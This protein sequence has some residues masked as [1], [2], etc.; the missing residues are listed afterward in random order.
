MKNLC[1]AGGS[2]QSCAAGIGKQIQHPNRSACGGHFIPDKIPVGCLLRK[3][4][5]MLKIHGLDIKSQIILISDLP[6]L[7]QMVVGPV[8]AAGRG[9]HISC[10]ILLPAGVVMGGVPDHLGVRTH[11]G[12]LTPALQTLTV[13]GIQNLIIFPC[14]GNPN[15]GSLLTSQYSLRQQAPP[16]RWV[17]LV[18]W[19]LWVPRVP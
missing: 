13:R 2:G 7:R 14:I 4:T 18:L 15:H 6:A 3:H 9:T 11:Q 19:V 12:V 5:G 17:P 8:A 1:T 10:V 16:D